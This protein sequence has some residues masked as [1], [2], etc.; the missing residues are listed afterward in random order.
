MCAET[1]NTCSRATNEIEAGAMSPSP[2]TAPHVIPGETG[3]NSVASL[4][5]HVYV[6]RNH[7]KDVEVYDAVTLTLERRLSVP[8]ISRTVAGLAACARNKCLYLSDWNS[9]GIHRVDLATDAV[10]RWP[11][12]KE[13]RCLSINRDHN[14]LVACLAD[15]KLQEFTT[16]GCL[17]REICLAAGV[18]SPCHAIQ[19]STGDY[20]V[21]QWK[22]PGVVSIVGE[23][24]GLLRSYGLARSHIG[25]LKCPRCLAVT[26]HGDIL[27]ADGG[28]HR[29]V[30]INC[31]RTRACLLPLPADIELTAPSSV[32][33]DETRDR[34]Y[35]GEM[36]GKFRVIVVNNLS[37]ISW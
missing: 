9:P 37:N 13:P 19:L 3:V 31:W 26:K 10:K 8:G 24:G 28:N 20:L 22:S 30:A 29:I 15:D 23:D 36:W 34:L 21:S 35:I 27:I 32:C 17:V 1:Y 12:A 14:L 33:L 18:G 6:A 7:K 4:D 25:P 11:V 5:D 2:P 16:G